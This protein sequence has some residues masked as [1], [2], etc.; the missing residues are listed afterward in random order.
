MLLLEIP[1]PPWQ[2]ESDYVLD[3][4]VEKEA[5]PLGLAPT[6]LLLLLLLWRCLGGEPNGNVVILNLKNLLY[7]IPGELWANGCWFAL[8]MVMH[9]DVPLVREDAPFKDVI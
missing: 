8:G 9:S 7:I 4:A 1:N 2:K 5:C 6:S 3:V